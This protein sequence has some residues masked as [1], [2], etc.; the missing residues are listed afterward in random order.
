[1]RDTIDRP[2]AFMALGEA[3][4]TAIE[5][6]YEASG[7]VLVLSLC[8]IQMLL[9][10]QNRT[11]TGDTYTDVRMCVDFLEQL[12]RGATPLCLLCENQ[13]SFEKTMPP[14]CLS[15][16]R[17]EYDALMRSPG[18]M[19]LVNGICLDCTAKPNL[20]ARVIN[21]YAANIIKIR[22]VIPFSDIA[23]NDDRLN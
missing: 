10:A 5:T 19:G 9:A 16:V 18:L 7:G 17:P 4:N 3:L 15:V 20:Q 11:L 22:R 14:A 1:M 23:A 13:F 21:Y 6:M 2:Q 12:Q 8:T